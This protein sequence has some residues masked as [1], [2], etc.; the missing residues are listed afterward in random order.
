MLIDDCTY[1]YILNG[2]KTDHCIV[3]AF[4]PVLI[5]LT[6]N[7]ND[8]TFLERKLSANGKKHEQLKIGS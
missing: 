3:L 6:A 7:V 1:L 8:V 4:V 5:N 2:E